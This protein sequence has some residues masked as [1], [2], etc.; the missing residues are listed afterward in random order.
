[1]CLL[2]VAQDVHDPLV[3]TP[4]DTG[5]LDRTDARLMKPQD[6]SRA[7]GG[8]IGHALPD[9]LQ[10]GIRPA[11]LLQ[12]FLHFAHHGHGNERSRPGAADSR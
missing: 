11:Q 8:D 3:G 12:E 1:M 2:G 7:T 5:N 10:L 4:E 6:E 9:F